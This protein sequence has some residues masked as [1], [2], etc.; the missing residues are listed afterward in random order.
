MKTGNSSVCDGDIQP[1]YLETES[2]TFVKNQPEQITLAE[3]LEF[4][5]F[6]RTPDGVLFVQNVEGNVVGYVGGN[7]GTVKGNVSNVRG[8]VSGSVGGN[9]I[10]PC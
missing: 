8:D 3:V 6:R 9:A 2:G 10:D 1:V 5:T 7:V 4:V